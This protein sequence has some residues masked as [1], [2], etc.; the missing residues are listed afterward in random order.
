MTRREFTPSTRRWA[1]LGRGTKRRSTPGWTRWPAQQR[2]ARAFASVCSGGSGGTSSAATAS[3]QSANNA[4]R[5]RAA[6]GPEGVGNEKDA[7]AHGWAVCQA[8]MARGCCTPQVK[9]PVALSQPPR[10]AARAV[11]RFN[12]VPARRKKCLPRQAALCRQTPPRGILRTSLPAPRKP[13]HVGGDGSAIG[14]WPCTV[15]RTAWGNAMGARAQRA[16]SAGAAAPEADALAVAPPR[17]CGPA[18]RHANA[19]VPPRRARRVGQRGIRHGK[20]RAIGITAQQECQRCA[21]QFNG[22][23]RVVGLLLGQHDL[24]GRIGTATLR[25]FSAGLQAPAPRPAPRWQQ[26]SIVFSC[27]HY[28]QQPGPG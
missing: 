8:F 11:G 22:A 28:R 9:S 27:S 25:Q 14:R 10:S 13:R 24:Q 4:A 18:W 1:T 23:H 6:Y 16:A 2:Q 5:T 26:P 21:R 3:P 20:R 17:Q 15:V 19:P 12:A 7:G